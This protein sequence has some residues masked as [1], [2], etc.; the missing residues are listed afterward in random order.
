MWEGR[1]LHTE[2]FSMIC[3]FDWIGGVPFFPLLQS[4]WFLCMK[5]PTHSWNKI[6]GET[7]FFLSKK[8]FNSIFNFFFG[9]KWWISPQIW[10][11]SASSSLF[12]LEKKKFPPLCQSKYSW[13]F[14]NTKIRLI[15]VKEKKVRT[16]NQVM[17]TTNPVWIY[18]TLAWIHTTLI[19]IHMYL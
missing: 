10:T 14:L 15:G 13:G 12:Y 4:A 19:W 18:T 8:F 7:F 1:G 16:M 9:E 2:L 3:Y 5:P 11:S 6:G 17:V